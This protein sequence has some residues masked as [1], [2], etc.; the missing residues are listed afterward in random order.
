MR[1]FFYFLILNIC[2]IGFNPLSA[3]EN[4]SKSKTSVSKAEKEND[5]YA[6][7]L[8]LS[9]E[10]SEKFEAINKTYQ[11]EVNALK[12]KSKTKKNTRKLKTLEKERDKALE[13]LLSEEQF[14]KYLEMRRQ[15]RGRLKTL[16]RKSNGQ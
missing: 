5:S 6:E 9:E 3:Q 14:E 1:P 11:E 8:N 2:L 16:I 7:K 12:I 15:E 13:N 4:Q 10:Q